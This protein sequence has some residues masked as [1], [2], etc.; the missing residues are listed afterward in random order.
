MKQ[1]LIF[2]VSFS[3]LLACDNNK[4][5]SS[6]NTETKSKDD[7]RNG[8]KEESGTN[9]G[10]EKIDRN[11][12]QFDDVVD[13][14]EEGNHVPESSNWSTTDVNAFLKSCVRE[15]ANGGM[16]KGMAQTYCNCML[17]K[18]STQYPDIKDAEKLDMESPSLQA[19]AKTCLGVK[20]SESTTSS[21]G[22]S[23]SQELAFVNSC[24][25]EAVKGGMEDLDA[26]SYCDCMQYK[27]E[28]LYPKYADANRLT[29]SDL[30]KPSMKKMIE[31]CLSE[32]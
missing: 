19:M 16:E 30:A 13:D 21:Q 29:E 26:Q 8:D 6:G 3:L 27:I 20:E 18:L 1:L 10:K 14:D 25:R 32:H 23:R 11:S 4:N 7:Y 24:V 31:N 12:G 5:K 17:R 15:A 22:W 2:L 28:K 9:D